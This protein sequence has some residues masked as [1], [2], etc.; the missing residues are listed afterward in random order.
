MK[1]LFMASSLPRFV[2]D[3]QAPFV[4]EQGQAWKNERPA[5]EVYILAPHDAGAARQEEVGGIE[6]HRFQYF[7]P[8]GLQALAYPAILPNIKR[9]PLL[10]GQVLPFLWAEY[11]AA[12]RIIREK[13]IDLVYAHWVMPQGLVARWLSRSTGVQFAIQNH[14]SDLS[15]FSKLGGLGQSMARTIIRESCA[16]FCVNRRQKEDALSLFKSSEQ[17]GIAPKITVLPMGVNLDEALTRE[18]RDDALAAPRYWFGMISRLSRKKGID[19]FIHAANRLAE[20]GH[21]VPVGIA[22]DGEYREELQNISRS[23]AIKFVGFVS[24]PEKIRFFN[25]TKFMVFPSISVGDDVEGLPV[26]LLEA[27]C[28]GKVVV[29]SRDTN[30]ELLPEW[31]RIR[32]DI[33]FLSDPRDIGAFTAAMQEMLRLE[34]AEVVERSNRLRAIMSRYHWHNLI[35]EYEAALGSATGAIGK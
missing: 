20:A 25:D 5:E 29:A 3:P 7:Y 2:N 9:N 30:L 19:L 23:E 21:P 32:D 31:D 13:G 4:L 28:C 1:I 10:I 33:F 34:A 12:K 18:W 17:P 27:L 16:M 15:V 11:S 8:D 24:G 14:S 6:I 22:G 35:K 26:A